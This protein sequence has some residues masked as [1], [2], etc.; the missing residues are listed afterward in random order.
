MT[1]I[2][3]FI[4]TRKFHSMLGNS[5]LNKSRQTTLWYLFSAHSRV[6]AVTCHVCLQPSATMA[7]LSR[8]NCRQASMV[9]L[10][11]ATAATAALLLCL[12]C[13]SLSPGPPL[14]LCLSLCALFGSAFSYQ[15]LQDLLLFHGRK[16]ALVL[17]KRFVRDSLLY[18]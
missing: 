18:I 1:C 3:P 17:V 15:E 12:R 7:S 10:L 16:H 9:V 4:C 14:S 8:P 11:Q 6:H 13:R 2:L 5:S